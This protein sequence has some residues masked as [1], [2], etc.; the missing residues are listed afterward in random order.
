VAV[1][2]ITMSS[3]EVKRVTNHSFSSSSP[4]GSQGR[5]TVLTAAIATVKPS[6]SLLIPM[7]AIMDAIGARGWCV[8]MIRN[9]SMI[10][11]LR[12]IEDTF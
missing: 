11:I 6:E 3:E 1:L 8:E 5:W 12:T 2:S 7:I 10:I 9:R 4:E